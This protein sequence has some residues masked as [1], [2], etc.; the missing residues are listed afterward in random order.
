MKKSIFLESRRC[1][2]FSDYTVGRIT[3]SFI[4]FLA[5]F[6]LQVGVSFAQTVTIVKT[7]AKIVD[8]FKEIRKQTGFDFVYTSSQ[9]SNAH[10]VTINVKGVSLEN[11]LTA[12]FKDQP[13]SY[14]IQ[15]KTIVIKPKEAIQT[16]RS[17]TSPVTKIREISGQVSGP[18]GRPMPGVTVLSKELNVRT[19][20]DR[21]G[22]Y[23]IKVSDEKEATL[24]F[25]YI[26]MQS[27]QIAVTSLQ[28]LNVTLTEI[29]KEMEEMVVT[30]Y[31]VL[32][33]SD[34]VGSVAS[35]DAKDLNFNGINTLE[36]AL[37]GKL[38]GVVVT[39]TS[40]MVGTKQNVRVRGTSTLIGTQEPIWVVDG[41]IQ[42]DPLPFKAQELNTAG[43]INTDNFDYLRNFV[44]NSIRWLN[45]NDIQDITI[46]KD[47]SATAIY[48]VRAANGVI[49]ITTK[50]GQVGPPAIVYSTNLSMT[51]SVDYD[52]LNLMNSKERVAV[53][54]EIYERGLTSPFVNN[55]IGY[56]GALNEYLYLKTISAD[57]FNARV[58]KMET[59]NTDWFKLLFRKPFS[60][61]HN[62]GISGG[63]S[64]TRYYSSFGYSENNGTAIGN[65][66]QSITGNLS[67]S[68]QLWKNL[69]FNVR[70]SASKNTTNGFY[71]ISPY[72]YA[73]K[74]NR[75][76]PAYTDN[77][78]YNFYKNSSGYL[79]NFLNER[80]ETGNVNNVL[81]ANG[82]LD[83][84]Y[85]IL[86][87]LRF[88]TLFS[89]NSSSTNGSAYATEKTEYVSRALRYA[90][91]GI[92][93]SD[94]AYIN[95]RLPVGG[96]Y[97]E[98]VSA[99]RTWG[100]RN[101]LSYNE[102]FAKKHTIALMLGWE[103][104]SSQYDGYQ[105]TD[106]GYLRDRGKSFATLPLTVTSQKTV[107]SLLT[108]SVPVVID[109]R[110]NTMGLYLTSSYTYDNRYIVNVSVRNDRSNRFGQFTNEK[111]NP[112]WAGGVRW[113]I[114]NEK[115][116]ETNNWLNGLS[117]R[118]SFGYQ[119]NIAANV[120]PDLIIKI[121]TGAPANNTESFT[122]E[123]LL[124]VRSLPYGDLRWE[125]TLS[126]NFGVDWSLFKN[127]I[128]GSFEYYTKKGRELIT[129]LDVP[130]EYGVNSMLVNGG[131][132]NN[133][134][135]EVTAN[136]VP[137]RTRNFTWSVNLNTSKNTN[138]VT[139]V[140]PQ[141]V[142]WQTAA[143]GQ[144]NA[145]GAPV[146]G[147]YA[148]KYTGINPANGEPTFD[149]STTPGA[150]PNNPTSFMQYMGKLDPD[151][152]SG[153]GMN[154]R[155][156][157][158]TLSS[159]FYLQVGGKRFLSPL[160][161]YAST[162]SGL[163]TEYENL[164][165]QI[166]DRWTP[167]NPNGTVPALPNGTLAFVALPNKD[168]R[169]TNNLYTFYNYST[170]RVVSATSLR[171]NN[172]N[173]SYS[174]PE[175]IIKKLKCK[176]IAL[177]GGVS[178]PFAINSSDFRGLDPEVATGGQPRT[179]TYTFNLN[180]SF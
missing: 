87:N 41:I 65:D 32:K 31:Q 81:T 20:T 150:D 10:P 14:S 4:V 59:V 80:N 106:Y 141:L 137:V 139:K 105:S 42:E 166:L 40:G 2:Y 122:G 84:N 88:Q 144:L 54:R 76:I 36:Q 95:S 159:S 157:M 26:G 83:V 125:N 130:T 56:A 107:N 6:V 131:S 7:N 180:L 136:F 168:Q 68:T 102:T 13:L 9:I 177:G 100:W 138:K 39:S 37:Q 48:G 30:G 155:Y 113:N 114:A 153:L 50:K 109:R 128:S 96:E 121:P 149:L 45:P 143:S 176:N 123:T 38:A 119:R 111:F 70:L 164:S 163:P 104:N 72:D 117:I 46:L 29:V 118:S 112:V 44:G 97:N 89:Y 156:K 146:S 126:L 79:F 173:L 51:E 154:F 148:F 8:I 71:Q 17:S 171:C 133:S 124:T 101:S 69:S 178:N 172:I 108:Q 58:A 147:F 23:Q 116:F 82:V 77:G 145:V 25:S 142:S 169:A 27:R 22:R 21:D 129:S 55:S 1:V 16:P 167:S 165:R 52:K 61:S 64:T 174:L 140:G 62:L 43:G 93:A 132:M 15:N 98:V 35:I 162:N 86:K 74:V 5:I 73:T 19:V 11:A 110:V 49:V 170:D 34:V 127:K 75:A 57:E 66:M 47:A 3:R 160:Y 67:I 175:S 103:S 53:S 12:C 120:S 85:Q 18:D 158:L 24:I 152:T 151:F 94:P 90:E 28:N 134:G 92:K 60:M 63:N 78:D 91:Y 179:R 135:Y 161:N 115:W 99:N 33:K